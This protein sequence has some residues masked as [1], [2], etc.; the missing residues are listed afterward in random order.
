MLQNKT[1]DR[2][3]MLSKIARRGTYLGLDFFS[4]GHHANISHVP[5]VLLPTFKQRP[6]LTPVVQTRSWKS[7]FTSLFPGPLGQ[8]KCYF[9]FIV[10]LNPPSCE[11]F[12]PCLNNC[13]VVAFPSSLRVP[14][15]GDC[16]PF[17]LAELCLN[18][19]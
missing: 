15:Q 18:G 10:T 17:G 16:D 9:V 8:M 14:W 3:L 12:S 13:S 1:K 19:L 5:L 11:M 6:V 2:Q 4:T 7:S